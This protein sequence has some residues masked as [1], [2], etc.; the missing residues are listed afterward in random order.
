MAL[1]LP[2][3]SRDT[4]ARR[5]R[6]E[7]PSPLDDPAIDAL[8]AHYHELQ[9]W[10]PI[11]SLVGPGAGPE[12]LQRHY[13]EAL[14]ALDWLD[15][16]ART[17]VDVGSGAGFPG[18]VLAAARPDLDV[19]LVEPRERR[20]SFLCQAARRASL[21]LRCLNVRVTSPLPAGLPERIDI[22]TLRA[23]RPE[24]IL[25]PLAE[26]LAPEAQVLLWVG[27]EDPPLPSGFARGRERKLAGSNVRRLLEIVPLTEK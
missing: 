16:Q 15:P 26:R 7:A 18:F 9:R 23:L 19:T 10:A 17:L 8:F 27:E 12:I 11:V 22:V 21:K 25:P 14:L 5:L 2:D 13:G 24:A 3:Y 6:A 4:F 20:W 1:H